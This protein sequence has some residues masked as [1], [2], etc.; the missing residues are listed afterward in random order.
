MN[1]QSLGESD[2]YTDTT[3]WCIREKCGDLGGKGFQ[4]KGIAKVEA[5]RWD[6]AWHASRKVKQLMWQESSKGVQN[7]PSQ[8]V[9]L[10]DVWIILSR[11]QSRLTGSRKTLFLP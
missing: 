11:R 6:T 10:I 1:G 7:E 8:N 4:A 9:W 2:I 3:A 5:W